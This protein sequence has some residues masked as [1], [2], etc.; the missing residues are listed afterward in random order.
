VGD[1]AW[2]YNTGTWTVIEGESDRFF[3]DTRELTYVKIVPG[4]EEEAQLLQWKD[5]PGRG[6]RV[7]L[8]SDSKQAEHEAS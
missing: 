6:E 8:M 3:R 1:G 2:Y 7:I 5:G 4:A